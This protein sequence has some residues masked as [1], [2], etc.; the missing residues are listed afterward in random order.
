MGP[1]FVPIPVVLAVNATQPRDLRSVATSA[2]RPAICSGLVSR[3]GQRVTVWDRARRPRLQRY[4]DALARGYSQ[5]VR[6]PKLTLQEV[7]VADEARPNQPATRLLEAR[8][9]LALG[10]AAGALQLFRVIARKHASVVQS[11]E[12]LHDHALAALQA[13]EPAEALAQYRALVSRAS[14]LGSDRRRQHVFLEAAGLALEQGPEGVDEA[15]GYLAE[16]RRQQSLPGYRAYVDGLLALTLDRR[17]R[18][19][20]ARG[21]R[22]AG[23]GVAILRRRLEREATARRP[24]SEPELRAA[25]LH[26]VVAFALQK[27]D[28]GSSKAHWSKFLAA[29][30]QS[31]WRAHAQKYAG[32]AR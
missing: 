30:P 4:C 29:A 20:E 8:A 10:D 3:R 21:V 12:A 18:G 17:G 6:A 26:A 13:G 31:P 25:T 24:H 16:A 14:L 23:A 19:D 27:R 28:A 22:D 7:G 11:P 1:L 32:G 2:P 5:L 15:L 9:K